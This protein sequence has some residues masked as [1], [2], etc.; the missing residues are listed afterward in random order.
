MAPWRVRDF[1]ADDLDAVVRL[2][3]NQAASSEAPAFSLSDLIAAVRS[4]E[5]AVVAVVG[6]EL[7]GAA[8]AAVGGD[9]AWVMGISLAPAWRRRG[10]G[11]GM[12]RELE[13]RLVAAGVHRI[14]C[15]LAGESDLGALALDHAGYTARGGMVLYQRLEPVDPGS[16]GVLG[17]LGGQ[18]V[19]AGAWDQL[20]GMVREKEL[21]ERRVILPLAQ[22]QLAERL[23]LVPPRAIVLFG[24]PGT[25]K[26]SFAKGAASQLGWPFVELFPSRLAG[27]S[28]AGLA[29]ALREAF[30]LVADLDKVVVFIDE[31]EE[32]AGARRPRTVSAA[33]GVTNEMLKLI[34]PFREQDARLLICA[35]NSVRALDGAFLRHGRFDYVIPVG[36]PDPAAREAI[37][38][39]YLT[40][41][42]HAKLDMAT[43]VEESRLFTPADIEF[44]ARRTAQLAFERVLFEGGDEEVT[45]GDIVHAIGQTRRTLTPEL[46]AEFE[47]DIQ[48]YARV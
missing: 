7:V 22:P 47:Q 2:W 41:I 42:P 25:G 16:A 27:E 37:W 33:Q 31:V 48:D 9:R 38:D 18:I 10:I 8:V 44:A 26:T 3:D 13:R 4:H 24:P 23:G 6:E 46:V 5:P 40:V 29:A 34:P 20:G 12:L 45:T 21:I 35:T 36:P 28:P 39:R 11:S 15:L 1:H 32:I 43:I 17:Q 19:R 30:S 14:Q